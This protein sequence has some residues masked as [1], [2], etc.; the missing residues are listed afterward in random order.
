MKKIV[1]YFLGLFCFM[2]ITSCVHQQN[3]IAQAELTD[4]ELN[5]LDNTADKYFIFD[6]FIGED[7]DE[8][9]LKMEKFSFG[10]LQEE[11]VD[12]SII[13]IE[14]DGMIVFS[15]S[16]TRRD[17][18]I[19]NITAHSQ[20]K[21]GGATTFQTFDEE[22]SSMSSRW[23]S[24]PLLEQQ[25]KDEGILLSICYTSTDPTMGER[26]PDKFYKKS[27]INIDLIKEFDVV[28]ILKYKFQ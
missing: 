15:T 28:F 26:L 17:D 22:L 14:K 23:D 25:F 27:Q 21:I 13:P 8:V 12:H 19:F 4:R 6:F 9:E 18:P 7:Y 11:L 16:K 20:D 10:T 24:N 1:Y 5:I 3:Y 2:M